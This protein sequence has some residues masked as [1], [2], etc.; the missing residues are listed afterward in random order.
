LFKNSGPTLIL[1]IFAIRL[2]SPLPVILTF[3]SHVCTNLVAL[4]ITVEFLPCLSSINNLFIDFL[5]Q[6]FR[7]ATKY[8]T[9][10]KAA[11]K[12][13]VPRIVYFNTLMKYF[14][15]NT[16]TVTATVNICHWTHKCIPIINNFE[17]GSF[18][19]Y[20]EQPADTT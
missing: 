10:R 20:R 16:S 11:L 7:N 13:L 12:N 2:T 17:F 8:H 3:F 18:V 4:E 15:L 6:I 5:S 1:Q 19:S 9:W 14:N